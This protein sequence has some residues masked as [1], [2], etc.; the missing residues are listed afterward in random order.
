MEDRY[1]IP[2][3]RDGL[4]VAFELEVV[5]KN[6]SHFGGIPVFTWAEFQKEISDAVYF[7]VQVH[8]YDLREYDPDCLF[9]LITKLGMSP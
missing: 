5:D 8:T 3:M 2:M 6:R 7:T 1:Q 9:P 4:G